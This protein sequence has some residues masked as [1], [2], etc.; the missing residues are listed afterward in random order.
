MKTRTIIYIA[1]GLVGAG[2]LWYLYS[3][4]KGLDVTGQPIVAGSEAGKYSAAG[5]TMGILT[6]FFEQTA[7]VI[8]NW[9]KNDDHKTDSETNAPGEVENP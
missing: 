8:N 2:L 1:L 3:K 6:S 4:S 9:N 7:G 5:A